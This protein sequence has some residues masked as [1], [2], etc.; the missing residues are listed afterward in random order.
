MSNNLQSKIQYLIKLYRD[1][2]RLV[3]H[4]A[5]GTS[6]PKSLALRSMVRLEFQKHK[7]E[8][9]LEKI[10]IHKASAIRALSNYMLYESGVKDQKLGKA[11][12]KFN[13]DTSNQETK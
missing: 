1:C 5:P 9:D 11:M 2:L 3:R 10:E 12:K 7:D 4:M 6:S 8:T 13:H